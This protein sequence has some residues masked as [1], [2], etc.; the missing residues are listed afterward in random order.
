MTLTECGVMQKGMHE[1]SKAWMLHAVTRW[2]I[3]NI[4]K[5]LKCLYL[6]IKAPENYLHPEDKD[7]MIL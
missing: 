6:Q 7:T 5:G 4:L 3:L 1:D 2:I